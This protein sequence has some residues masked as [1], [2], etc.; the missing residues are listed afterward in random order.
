[1]KVIRKGLSWLSGMGFI[2]SK[3]ETQNLGPI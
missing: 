3:N 2:Y 1:L